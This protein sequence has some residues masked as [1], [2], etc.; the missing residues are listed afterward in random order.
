MKKL[1]L[2]LALC[3]LTGCLAGCGGGQ[4]TE[5]IPRLTVE[6]AQGGSLTVDTLG[7]KEYPLDCGLTFFGAAGMQEQEV[8][9]LAA[10]LK[11]T[12][13]IVMVIEEPREGTVLQ[14]CTLR[15]YADMLA[16]NNGLD[17]FVTDCYG[18]LATV[19]YALSFE[20][21]ESFFYYVTVKEGGGSFWLIQIAC[22]A[23]M[24]TQNMRELARWSATFTWSDPAEG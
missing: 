22:R 6:P 18:S 15:D 1:A 10:Y 9:G 13:A 4:E 16:R 17:P 12:Y 14:D 23:E 19:N 5:D 2:L 21:E 20:G 3:L 11:N 7:L 24:A 8:E